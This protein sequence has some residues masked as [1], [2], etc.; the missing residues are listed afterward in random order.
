MKNIL[1]LLTLVFF[2]SSCET[3]DETSQEQQ[4]EQQTEYLD[5]GAVFT[6]QIVKFSSEKLTEQQYQ[7]TLGDATIDIQKISEI[8]Y[9]LLMPGNVD[10]GDQEMSVAG[11]DNLFITVNIVETTLSNSPDE[12]LEPLFNNITTFKET[13]DNESA[14]ASSVQAVLDAFDANYQTLSMADKTI[15]AKLY[16]ANSTLMDETILSDYTRIADTQLQLVGK[17]LFAVGAFSVATVGVIAV[18]DLVSKGGLAVIASIA[19]YKAYDY[20]DRLAEDTLKK[21]NMVIN[22]VTSA[23]DTRNSALIELYNNQNNSFPLETKD[24]VL[25]SSDQNDTNGNL[26]DFFNSFS[27]FNS[28]VDRLNVAI[29]FVNDNL[30]FSNIPLLD[31]DSL[32]NSAPLEDVTANQAVFQNANF[33]ISDSR[34]TLNNVSFSNGN[35]NIRA[36]FVDPNFSGEYVDTFLE[37]T[38]GDDF[39]ELEG[40]FPVRI[41]PEVVFEFTGLWN[42][43]HYEDDTLSNL[44]GSTFIEFGDGNSEIEAYYYDDQGGQNYYN[45]NWSQS[46]DSNTLHAYIFYANVELRFDYDS[47]NPNAIMPGQC[48]DLCNNGYNMVVEKM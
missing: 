38:Y 15:L 3:E 47:E 22:Y 20:K 24:R 39:N 29:Q 34:I 14:Y 33:T 8:E 36:S 48:F 40:K 30:W 6:Q 7:A 10:L 4:Q 41:F 44:I 28:N 12:T 25:I 16:T 26:V 27:V 13:I 11:I 46:F 31:R 23:L 21:V 9:V 18:P 5:L 1:L 35:I 19:L 45:Y 17:Y 37:F 42:W 2:L 43:R 32:P